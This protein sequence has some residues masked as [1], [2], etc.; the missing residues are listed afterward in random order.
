MNNYYKKVAEYYD[1]DVD[2][3][4]ESRADTNTSLQRIR[5]A[6]RTV[7]ERYPFR[8]ALEIG[9]GPGLDAE[10]A[11]RTFSSSE[12]L[13][14]DVS[15]KMVAAAS[16]RTTGLTNVRVMQSS[17]KEISGLSNEE[18]EM[19]YVFFGALNTVENLSS[20]AEQIYKSMKPGAHAVL[21]FVNKWYLREM[22]VNLIK[23]NIKTA[24]ARLRL[25]WGGYSPK[26]FLESRCY[27]PKEVRKAFSSFQEL[28]H[29]GYSITYPAWYNHHKVSSNPTK[30]EKR[31]QL[32]D[33]LNGTSF[34]KFGEYTLFVF[35]KPEH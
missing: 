20:A 32:D 13:A 16:E 33:K 34:W 12:I 25:T 22:I 7:V 27:S 26:R 35:R 14:I 2:L 10:W 1:E 4:F 23:L 17:E 11:G 29:R 28:D 21:T 15:A 8:S 5:N 18:F 30:A 9:C 31:W 19:V 3:G 24:F 6:F